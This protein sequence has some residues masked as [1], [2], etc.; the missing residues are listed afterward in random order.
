[1]VGCSIGI[2]SV[3][4]MADAGNNRDIAFGNGTNH[5]F[6]IKSPQVFSTAP[7]KNYYIGFTFLIGRL[8]CTSD[9][10]RRFFTLNWYVKVSQFCTWQ[11]LTK[12]C[13]DVI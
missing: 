9:L 1:M 6:I 13:S 7:A 3:F 5:D 4:L 11:S 8:N 10:T 12:Y 2:G